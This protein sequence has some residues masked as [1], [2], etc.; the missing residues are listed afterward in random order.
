[1]QVSQQNLDWVP[2]ACNVLL[3]RGVKTVLI[4]LG[5]RGAV[6]MGAGVVG[7]QHETVAKVKTVDTAGAGDSF[8]GALGFYMA[9]QKRRSIS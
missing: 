2:K 5:S 4:T 8:L 9:S 3:E 6:A 7:V 1:M